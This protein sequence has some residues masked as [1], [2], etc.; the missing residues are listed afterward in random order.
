M[1]FKNPHVSF[2]TFCL[3][4]EAEDEVEVMVIETDLH[5]NSRHPD[6]NQISVQRL[7]QSAKAY[8]IEHGQ[9]GIIRLVCTRS[10]DI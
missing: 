3:E 1:P 8:R 7:I 6:Y 5:L 2:V 10:G 9:N 4:I